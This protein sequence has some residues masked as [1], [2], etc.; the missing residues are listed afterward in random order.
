MIIKFCMKINQTLRKE[1][2]GL[3][4]DFNTRPWT[5]SL[6]IRFQKLHILC[7]W[8]FIGDGRANSRAFVF[9]RDALTCRMAVHKLQHQVFCATYTSPI[10][11]EPTNAAS[12][13]CLL[14]LRKTVPWK[15]KKLYCYVSLE[16]TTRR[17]AKAQLHLFSEW[18][19]TIKIY[20]MKIYADHLH[21]STS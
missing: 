20:S 10:R 8:R 11:E 9:C 5:L 15:L 4:F 6:E 1:W 19:K 17:P 7:T 12:F 18:N 21:L 16:E 3:N 14:I 2:Q 13:Q